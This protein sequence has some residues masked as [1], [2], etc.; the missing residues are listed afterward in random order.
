MEKCIEKSFLVQLEKQNIKEDVIKSLELCIL[1][2]ESNIKNVNKIINKIELAWGVTE[3]PFALLHKKEKKLVI[4]VHPAYFSK[5]FRDL[6][7]PIQRVETIRTLFDHESFEAIQ[8]NKYNVSIFNILWT[9]NSLFQNDKFEDENYNSIELCC[10]NTVYDIKTDRQILKLSH[11]PNG[12]RNL[13]NIFHQ[14]E[15][16]YL[17]G[18]RCIRYNNR[19]SVNFNIKDLT[20]LIISAAR[21]TVIM[22]EISGINPKLHQARFKIHSHYTIL[23][24]IL[25]FPE[26]KVLAYSLYNELKKKYPNWKIASEKAL[27]IEELLTYNEFSQLS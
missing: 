8:N 24:K 7:D 1:D 11:G 19:Y 10:R 18:V 6:A 3:S 27:E 14:K 5:N 16:H 15:L 4:K 20:K 23:N 26:L 9:F 21:K 17:N 25:R 13:Y 2:I 22:E 12:L